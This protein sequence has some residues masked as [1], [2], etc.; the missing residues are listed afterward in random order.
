MGTK[1]NVIKL[2][3][4]GNTRLT[5][6]SMQA[7]TKMNNYNMTYV[8]G[9][10]PEKLSS[11]VN[12]VDL[13]SFCQDNA[14]VLDQSGDWDGFYNYCEKQQIDM[15]ITL[16][17]S[18]IIPKKMANSF[19]VIG[20]HGA[21]LPDV[22][23][24]ASLVWGRILDSGQWGV[25]IMKIGERV[26]SGDIL[27]VKRFNYDPETTEKQFT[28][29]ADK[30]SVDALVEVLN[31]EQELQENSR[32]NVRVSKHTDSLKAVEILRY[33]QNN[34]LSVYMPP[35][36]PDDGQVKP[37]WPDEFKRAFKIANDSPYPKW[38]E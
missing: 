35:R 15:I 31:G 23:G 34:G 6:E 22:Q 37:E 3:I 36:T 24:G 14:I 28:D 25:S 19:Y 13:T 12:S 38:R 5:L 21:V 1:N 16:G 27:K 26:D 8:F 17:D 7:I 11:K 10:E 33:C 4:T 29:M 20:N 9:L 30:L 32:W 2:A 18:R